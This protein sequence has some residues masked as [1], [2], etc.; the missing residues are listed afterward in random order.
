MH[1]RFDKYQAAGNDFIIIDNRDKSFPVGRKLINVLCDRRFGVGA[2]GLMLLEEHDD[3]DFRMVYF[4]ADGNESTMCGNGG[5]C[6]VAFARKAGI[7]A[8]QTSF[9]AVDG[10]HDAFLLENDGVRLKMQDVLKV[11]KL[12]KGFYLDTGS[13]HLVVFVDNVD[14]TDVF[15]LGRKLRNNEKFRDSGGTNVNFVEWMNPGV[16]KVRTYERGVEDETLACG[17]GVVASAISTTLWRNSDIFSYN[18]YARGGKL[19]VSF[20]RDGNIFKDIWLEGPAEHVF[21]GVIDV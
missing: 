7:F 4:N 10:P 5:R 3:F 15:L 2:D 19:G 8:D 20:K 21:E 11:E 17:T 12:E 13:P 1:L 16:I 14:K 9:I 18:I 6:I